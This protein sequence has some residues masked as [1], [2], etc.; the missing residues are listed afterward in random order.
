MLC[1]AR[2]REGRR[3]GGT[4]LGK[5]WEGKCLRKWHVSRD[6]KVRA[7]NLGRSK[8]TTDLGVILVSANV[9]RKLL[10]NQRKKLERNELGREPVGMRPERGW[11]RAHGGA[12]WAS[13]G[14]WVLPFICLFLCGMGS[15]GKFLGRRKTRS[16]L[17][18]KIL[19]FGSHIKTKPQ[20]EKERKPVTGCKVFQVEDD[21]RWGEVFVMEA[22][23]STN[24]LLGLFWMYSQ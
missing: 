2:A 17:K 8:G 13:Q 6:E 3:E 21:G 23:Q 24:R 18:K 19:L 15:Q 22:I 5:G 20:V 11:A 12:V 16:E 7:W 10:F 1:S 4:S 14:A 9:Q